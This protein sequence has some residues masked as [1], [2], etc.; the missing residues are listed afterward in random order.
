MATH[1]S[2]RG[3]VQRLTV[4]VTR[5]ASEVVPWRCTVMLPEERDRTLRDA[6][7]ELASADPD[8]IAIREND[9]AV[10][11]AELARMTDAVARAVEEPPGSVE[12][13][14][15]SVPERRGTPVTVLVGHGVDALVMTFGVMAGG[16]VTVPLDVNDPVDRLALVH[17]EAG[18]GLTVT[19][20]AHRAI[21]ES[22]VDGPIILLEDVLAT[23]SREVPRGFRHTPDPRDVALVL[24]TSGSTGTP[25]GVVRDHET[26]LRHGAAATYM[27][28]IVPG[29][30]VLCWGSFAS[31]AAYT[32]AMG[33]LLGGATLHFYDV[34]SAGL[35]A[36]PQW[37]V[38]NRITVVPLVPS[39][40]HALTDAATELGAPRMETVRLVTL[41]G[42]A[43]YGRDVR[44]ARSRFAADAVFRNGYGSS[45][46][47]SV[48][49]WVVTDRD[50]HDDEQPVPA[51]NPRPWAE[52]C[53]VGEDGKP[54]PDGEPGLIDVVHDHAALGYWQDPALT[55]EKFWT[56]PDGRRGFHTADRGRIRPDGVLEYLGRADDRVKVRA[57]M[58][59]TS[60]V[61]R[62]LVR[63][64]GVARAAVVPAPARDGGTRIVAYI[65]PE[66][67][68]SPS[69]WQLRRDLAAK[70][71]STMVPSAIV[72]MDSLPRAVHGKV[73]RRALP[74]PPDVTRHAYRPPV[75]REQVLA[76]LIGSVLAVEQV[77]LDDDFFELG[78]DSLAAVELMAAIDEQ[79]GV[80]LA[81]ATL[82]DA[83]TPAQLAPLLNHR[84][85]ARLP[86]GGRASRRHRH[87]LLLRGR[88]W[89]P[90]D[91]V[92]RARACAA[93]PPSLLRDPGPWAR[94]ARAPRPE[95]RSLRRAGT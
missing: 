16:R 45:E 44:R 36:F 35:R 59:S 28:E 17:R 3:L 42:E 73:D 39:V 69:T 2:R 91:L 41:G 67:G 12:E 64:D 56:L 55:A 86:D 72:L 46:V 23:A 34:Q 68:A 47:P 30:R 77:G 11:Y 27:N 70:L 71:P 90:R 32:R 58:V 25:K 51:G 9:R 6:L 88:R 50:D 48:T 29:D 4:E 49:G 92:A 87:A 57:G 54:V 84:R 1:R 21:A 82:L 43:L 76:D 26:V 66:V 80:N 93:R 20:H 65:V 79:F 19:D 83:P 18:A 10:T 8:R 60:E 37:A 74:P 61:E 33:A 89:F 85:R 63:L 5:Q 95:R 7:H 24:F 31:T 52:F 22:A 14:P 38:D 53:V 40:L 75:G 78:G 81:P 15:G 62:V 94:R 13:P